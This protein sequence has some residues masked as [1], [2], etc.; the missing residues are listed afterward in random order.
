MALIDNIGD[1]AFASKYPV[2][3]IIDDRTDIAVTI[4]AAPS[5]SEPVS[6]SGTVSYPVGE[7]VVAS[8]V[9]TVDGTNYYPVGAHAFGDVSGSEQETITC[10]IACSPTGIFVRATN[11]FTSEVTFDIIVYLESVS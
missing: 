1:I 10:E 3:K 8:G 6:N 2:D 9:F 11:A 4:G 7:D 5:P